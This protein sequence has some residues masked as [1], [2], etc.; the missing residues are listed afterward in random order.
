MDCPCVSPFAFSL[1]RQQLSLRSQ[2]SIQALS[3]PAAPWQPAARWPLPPCRTPRSTPWLPARPS[4]PLPNMG[5]LTTR[6]LWLSKPCA[7]HEAVRG[8]QHN[9]L[10]FFKFFVQCVVW[11]IGHC[12][13]EWEPG[14]E[15]ATQRHLGSFGA[16]KQANIPSEKAARHSNCT[17]A[18]FLFDWLI[19][20]LSEWVSEWVTDLLIESFPSKRSQVP[21]R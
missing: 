4:V 5:P 21:L 17:G 11:G 6:L 7:L 2:A 14:S 15:S 13:N 20:W 9:S 18:E 3:S 1:P 10:F 12:W 19:D 8:C 16:T